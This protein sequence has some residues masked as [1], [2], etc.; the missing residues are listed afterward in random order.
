MDLTCR[1]LYCTQSDA[2]ITWDSVCGQCRK[3]SLVCEVLFLSTLLQ[4][5]YQ[6]YFPNCVPDP[7]WR[8][9]D[10]IFHLQGKSQHFLRASRH[11][12]CDTIFAVIV[13][14]LNESFHGFNNIRKGKVNT[15]FQIVEFW[16]LWIFV[17]KKLNFSLRNVLVHWW[18]GIFL[19]LQPPIDLPDSVALVKFCKDLSVLSGKSW[20]D[21]F[22]TNCFVDDSSV[23]WLWWT[24]SNKIYRG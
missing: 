4:I 6:H 13:S 9:E 5:Q 11:F 10:E 3:Q 14:F 12:I 24:I 18:G 8:M 2:C 23:E 19:K 16:R 17:V 7:Y 15:R 1:H 22:E 20:G 21:A